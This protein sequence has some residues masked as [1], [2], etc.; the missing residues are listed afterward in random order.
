MMLQVLNLT[1]RYVLGEGFS[2]LFGLSNRQTIR[3][4]DGINLSVQ[5]GEVLGLVG[6][7]G[8]GKS[9]L[10]RLL[11]GLE[12]QDGGEILFGGSDM[13][14]LRHDDR[15]AFHRQVQMVFQDPYGSL[16]PQHT[17]EEVV[18]RPL[19]YQKAG[20]DK[21]GLRERAVEALSE[22]ELL[23]PERYLLRF[24]HE[25]S[26]G[27]R[28]RVCIARALVLQPDLIVADEPISM[29]DVS[30]KW[31]IVRLLKRLVQQ[32]KIGLLYITHDL[33]SVPTVCD[34]IAIMYL[35][36]I[37]ES[38]RCRDVLDHPQHPYTQALLA[39][40]PNPNPDIERQRPKISGAIPS[41]A[42]VPL[43][44]RFHP[45]C[46]MAGAECST[47]EPET[48]TRGFHRVECHFAFQ[49]QLNRAAS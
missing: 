32:R 25:L 15:R 24:P 41:A 4:V 26:G 8:C 18:S 19:V 16:N 11:V 17:I 29:L 20:L 48:Q 46:P 37:V 12:E 23:P 35:G 30:I 7:S 1:K 28:Q 43:G 45:R 13:K 9:T 22:A 47:A 36:R 34:K 5:P 2:S 42:A 39:A 10:A 33:S 49:S 38:G 27:Q 21:K 40:T 31:G 44:C 6:E 3:A 14:K